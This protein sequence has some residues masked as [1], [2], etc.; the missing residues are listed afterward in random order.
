MR[1]HL[2]SA[3]LTFVLPGILIL[4]ILALNLPGILERAIFNYAQLSRL[5]G[6][7]QPSLYLRSLAH[8]LDDT[9]IRLQTVA[10]LTEAGQQDAATHVLQPLI[11]QHNLD[12]QAAQILL[13]TLIIGGDKQKAVQTYQHFSSHP[14]LS[15]GI[16]AR[17]LSG[18]L[19]SGSNV[20]PDVTR[21][22]LANVFGANHHITPLRSLGKRLSAPDFWDTTLGQKSR[23]ALQWSTQPITGTDLAAQPPEPDR[24]LVAAQLEVAAE[25]IRFGPELVTNGSFEQYDLFQ[26]RLSGWYYSFMSIKKP[27]DVA[28]FVVGLDSGNP[29]NGS[30]SMRVDGLYREDNPSLSNARAGFWHRSDIT[31]Q[32]DTPYIV[33]FAYR[34]RHVRGKA[35][36]IWLTGEQDVFWRG[37]KRLPPTGGEWKQET[38]IGWNR[39]GREAT[40]RPLL[41]SWGQGSVWFDDFSVRELIPKPDRAQ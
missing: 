13:A 32:P 18:F 17:V 8:F 41:R 33:S 14:Q 21:H 10:A 25:S 40:I 20:P 35:A 15:P 39:S 30:L 6:I 38:I 4:A 7:V 37:E 9:H 22:L 23:A 36:A 31:I 11:N 16:A 27:F 29:W 1:H 26:D 24:A 2:A 3:R 12:G 5:H 19:K 28:A 34:T